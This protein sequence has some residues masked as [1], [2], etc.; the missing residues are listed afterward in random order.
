MKANGMV[1]TLCL[2][3]VTGQTTCQDEANTGT[4]NQENKQHAFFV[5]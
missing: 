5:V 1:G 3:H 4:D 2:M